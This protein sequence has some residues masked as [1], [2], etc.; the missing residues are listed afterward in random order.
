MKITKEEFQRSQK[1][2]AYT[3]FLGGIASKETLQKYKRT[4][5]RILCDILMDFFEGTI[6]QRSEQIVKLAKDDSDYVQDL[7]L[8]LSKKL[9]D[10]TSLNKNDKNYLNPSTIPNYF[11][12]LKKLFAMN[13]VAFSW[14][15]I[16]AT[17]P[18]IDNLDESREWKRHE[19]QTMLRFANGAVDRSIILV[20]SSSGIRS[21]GLRF[22]WGDVIP[23]YKVND[24]L[25]IDITESELEKAEIVC[26]VIQ[27]VYKGSDKSYPAF[28]TPEAYEAILDYKKEWIKEV[29][30]VPKLTDPI[31]KREGPIA[32]SATP[33]ALKK[34]IERILLSS[35]LRTPLPKGQKRHEVPTMNGFRRFWDKM[36][37]ESISPGSPLAYLIKI[38]YMMG[39]TGLTKLDRN[40]F[41]TNTL[42]LAADYLNAVPNLTISD[43]ERTKAEN[44]RLRTEK[45]EIEKKNE[46]LT[47][48][49]QKVDELWA[50]K[51]RMESS[52]KK[53][54]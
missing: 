4:L 45:S 54:I 42:E 17:F 11:K 37:K 14:T 16:E 41:K 32:I 38:E 29:G 12:P 23:I 36:C 1:E 47:E 8:T 2:S 15:R 39:H 52:R 46:N 48:A 7:M 25:K 31:F 30:R 24:E 18:E 53:K 5:N 51:E 6:E 49:L 33:A 40:Y 34:R 44:R 26:A 9:K 20:V 28:M 35:G 13:G 10:R 27:K 43:E 22:T 3:V 21:G 19:I 50:D